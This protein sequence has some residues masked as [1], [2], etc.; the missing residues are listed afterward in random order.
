MT[1]YRVTNYNQYS[2]KSENN[3][4]VSVIEVDAKNITDALNQVGEM[5]ARWNWEET[6]ANMKVNMMVCEGHF[7]NC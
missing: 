1:T 6:R 7:R 3:R 5:T 2:T 4:V